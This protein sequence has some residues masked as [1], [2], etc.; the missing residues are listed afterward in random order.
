M[1]KFK[2]LTTGRKM[3]V[4]AGNIMFFGALTLD[5]FVHSLPAAP[6]MW[7]EFAGLAIEIFAS[8][9]TTQTNIA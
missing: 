6:L 9:K 4:V 2:E 3:A 8:M 1:M 7:V 5:L